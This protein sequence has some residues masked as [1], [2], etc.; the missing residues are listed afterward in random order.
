MMNAMIELA[1]IINK[2]S[3]DYI[4]QLMSGLRIQGP[5]WNPNIIINEESAIKQA[6]ILADSINTNNDILYRSK[7][8]SKTYI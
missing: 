5:L 2:N 4:K 8:L 7:G 6:A 1:P 3:E